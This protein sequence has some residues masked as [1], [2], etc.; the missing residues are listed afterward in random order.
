[1]VATPSAGGKGR[2]WDNADLVIYYS[3]DYN[4]E[5]RDQSEMRV[6]GVEK[7]RGV[8]YVDLIVPGTVEMKILK[9]LRE[10][11]DLAAAITGDNWKEWLI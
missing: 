2:T 3:S 1:M 7:K 5:N 9:A 4:L 6:Q 11:M 8:E 10:K